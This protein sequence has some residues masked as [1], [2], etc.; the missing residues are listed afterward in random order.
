VGL[1][2]RN[3]STQQYVYRCVR[4]GDRVRKHY[5]GIDSD[6]VV[7]LQARAARLAKANRDVEAQVQRATR[8]N[9]MRQQSCFDLI[10]KSISSWRGLLVIG[11]LLQPSGHGDECRWN[12]LSEEFLASIQER[13]K[14]K[15]A[16]TRL[17]ALVRDCDARVPGAQ[18]RL[19]QLV[20]AGS[21]DFDL[22]AA[23]IGIVTNLVLDVAAGESAALR[24]LV[25][26]RLN[27]GVSAAA[28][29]TAGGGTDAVAADNAYSTTNPVERVLC[30]SAVLSNLIVC[31]DLVEQ[32][33][34]RNR[35]KDAA[36]WSRMAEMQVRHTESLF[37]TL[38]EYRDRPTVRVVASP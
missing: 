37:Q 12:D 15:I 5:L 2:N 30:H 27:A 19:D 31:F 4:I 16:K 9:R 6:P 10:T 11:P 17:H 36:H 24:N 33:K 32:V 14:M 28:G 29:S 26:E 34:A 1:E 35:P 22:L 8:A 25:V 7:Q 21:N 3:N 38:L 20:A 13:L 23:V 18:E